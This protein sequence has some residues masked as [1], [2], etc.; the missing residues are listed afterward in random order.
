MGNGDLIHLRVGCQYK[1]SGMEII[2]YP[3]VQDLKQGRPCFQGTSRKVVGQVDFF[4]TCPKDM[5][6][7]FVISTPDNDLGHLYDVGLP[8]HSQIKC[9][10]MLLIPVNIKFHSKG[11][12]EHNPH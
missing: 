10:R 7:N 12:M 9:R 4:C 8:L 2:G 5:Y 1:Q 3:V 6:E 11:L